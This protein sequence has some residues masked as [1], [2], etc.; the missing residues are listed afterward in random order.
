MPET[1]LLDVRDLHVA[2]GR[3]EALHGVSLQVRRGEVVSIVGAN[4]AGKSTLIN[5]LS[6][7]LPIKSGGVSVLGKDISRL[8]AASVARLGLRQVPEGRRVFSDLSVED[9]LRLGGY[10]RSRAEIERELAR[11]F[12]LFPRLAERRA[13]AAGSLSGGEQQMVAIGRALTGNPTVLMLDEPSMGLAPLITAEIFRLIKRLKQEMS[14]SI[15]IVEQNAR[16]ALRLSDR[17]Y[18][19][20]LG[21]IAMSG[22][23]ADL[24]RDPRVQEAFLGG[25]A[26]AAA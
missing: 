20:A 21:R 9:N 13:Q 12:D 5:A 17:A 15:L 23:G 16:A 11:V 4:G 8:S 26:A 24:L 7:V 14:M 1:L 6:G 25:A 2:Y 19:L 22:A 18:V 10:G 3:V